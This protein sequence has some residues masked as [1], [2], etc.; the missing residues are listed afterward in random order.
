MPNWFGYLS[1]FVDA[2]ENLVMADDVTTPSD[3]PVSPIEKEKFE[4]A[5]LDVNVSQRS[6]KEKSSRKMVRTQ[7][8]RSAWD[9]QLSPNPHAL[10]IFRICSCSWSCAKRRRMSM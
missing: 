4:E 7:V 10:T 6:R 1:D 5:L 9:H 3:L 2:G 8:H